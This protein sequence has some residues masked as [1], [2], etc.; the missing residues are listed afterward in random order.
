M[1]VCRPSSSDVLTIRSQL[2]FVY[3]SGQSNVEGEGFRLKMEADI[4]GLSGWRLPFTKQTSSFSYKYP[5]L[6]SNYSS[7]SRFAMLGTPLHES[8]ANVTIYDINTEN[9]HDYVTI[10]YADPS[11]PG[12]YFCKA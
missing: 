6:S 12:E 8:R 10:L 1:L 9:N 3:F 5:P 2:F 11:L 4:N 7:N